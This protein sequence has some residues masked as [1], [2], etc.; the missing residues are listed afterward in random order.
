MEFSEK[1]EKTQYISKLEN[2]V[3]II[4]NILALGSGSVIDLNT[5]NKL[6]KLKK[7]AKLMAKKLKNDEYEVA[8]VG[9][10]KAGKSTFANALMENNF[11][12]TKDARC[13]FTS[14]RI[15]YNNDDRKDYAN[16]KFFSKEEF[17]KDFKDKLKKLGLED[18]DK[19][20]FRD[21]SIEQYERL[22]NDKVSEDK[23]RL[24]SDTLNQ[25]ILSVLNNDN[26]GNI[27]SLLG[28][29][30]M[31]IEADDTGIKRLERYI[32]EPKTAYAVKEVIIKSKNLGKMKNAVIYD[33]PGFDSPTELH[34]L[35]TKQ[36]MEDAD[37]IIA[38]AN[39]AAPS[40]TGPALQV[41]RES[42]KEGNLLSDKLFVF[43][44]KIDH[45]TKI[46]EDMK[47]TYDE[48]INNRRILKISQENRVFFGSARARLNKIYPDDEN[49]KGD[50]RKLEQLKD[51]D[52]IDAIRQALEAYKKSLEVLKKM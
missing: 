12:P 13:T 4:D 30:P 1:N 3:Q 15:E 5:E 44:N 33:V 21:L 41:F 17:E 25:D 37:A 49:Y 24:Y 43:A 47:T 51:G 34:K 39:G 50:Y 19:Y 31:D 20:S 7:D 38:V 40:I 14:T 46:K 35:Q 8:I 2:Q 10:E 29:E 48:W 16:V 27:L 6:D 36:R 9:L 26:K 23:K 28:N 42:D 52:G 18:V 45:A 32:T 22:Y 11:L